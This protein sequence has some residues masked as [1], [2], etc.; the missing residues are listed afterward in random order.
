M[1]HF[2]CCVARPQSRLFCVVETASLTLNT[3]NPHNGDGGL[4]PFSGTG[5]AAMTDYV[6][7]I[8]GAYTAIYFKMV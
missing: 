5:S 4:P 8:K 6:R 7:R 3:D 2:R 1:Q